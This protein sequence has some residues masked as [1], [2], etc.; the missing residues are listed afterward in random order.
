MSE[1]FSLNFGAT[2]KPKASQPSWEEMSI[3]ELKKIYREKVGVTPR[4]GRDV[5]THLMWAIQNPEQERTALHEIDISDD[6]EDLSSPYKG[7]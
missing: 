1:Q 7:H 4:I 6:R 3:E 5:R 2:E